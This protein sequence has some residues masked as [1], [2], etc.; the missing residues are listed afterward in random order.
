METFY[1]LALLAHLVAG[2]VALACFWTAAWLRKGSARHRT[3]GGVFLLAMVVVLAS[4]V[5]LVAA[6]VKRGE[7]VGA[8]FLGF[9]LVL[10]AQGSWSAWRAI[11][12]RTRP[13]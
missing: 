10:V 4:G 6:L 5:P 8:L 11:R 1:R 13:Q 9:L 2:S 12:D 3:V 7:A